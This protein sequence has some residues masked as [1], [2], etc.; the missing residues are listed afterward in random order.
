MDKKKFI[1]AT[2]ENY[3]LPIFLV[4]ISYRNF[5]RGIDL[6][7]SGY[8]ID[9]FVHFNEYPG[10][11]LISIFWSCFLGNVF[12]HLPFGNSW[13]GICFY[14]TAIIAGLGVVAYFWAKKYMSAW[15]AAFTECIALM[16]CW[17]PCTVVYDY[18]SF[19]LLEISIV[20]ILKAMKRDS[21]VLLLCAG[22]LLGLNTFVRIS[23]VTFCAIA[24]VVWFYALWEKKA[25]SWTI[26]KTLWGICGFVFGGAVSFVTVLAKYGWHTFKVS[27]Y[28][29]FF[30][31]SSQENYGLMYMATYS[32]RTILENFY[33]LKLFSKADNNSE[34][35]GVTCLFLLMGL[36]I[37]L[38]AFFFE[39]ETKYRLLSII[40]WVV[41]YVTPLGSNNAVY[42]SM[43]N[44]FLLIPI[45]CIY[46][47]RY[48]G[49]VLE[50]K[51]Y[52]W[53]G[54]LS[55]GILIA[56][57]Y[58]IK[59]IEFGTGFIWKDKIEDKVVAEGSFVKGMWTSTQR[60]EELS[61]LEQ[62]FSEN[63]LYGKY[64]LLYCDAPALA[65][66]LDIQPIATSPWPDWYAYSDSKFDDAIMDAQRMIHN[67]EEPILIIHKN[68]SA[69]I[70]GDVPAESSSL[71]IIDAKYYMLSKFVRDN[72]YDPT[73]Q[74][75]NFVVYQIVDGVDND[76]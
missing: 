46:L 35:L 53:I 52:V 33:K 54:I 29:L 62:Y 64:G 16:Y 10:E 21:S 31:S 41:F 43:L 50:R 58:S 30:L 75:D 27:I 26:K 51:K 3:V 11:D 19:L 73:F 20:L 67:G 22:I 9:Y 14:S 1:K 61:K 45:E 74:S 4:L 37:S 39:K 71:V 5:N 69:V 59:G 15:M 25:I 60:K 76:F 63:H 23:N 40:Y 42:L 38:V 28:N 13:I 72:G 24:I 55:I 18:L 6:T 34:V 66:I 68:Y 12:T 65:P 36:V 56:G 32:F 47:R 48:F 57:L 49:I 17:N 44:M 70:E 7:D 2:I 8:N